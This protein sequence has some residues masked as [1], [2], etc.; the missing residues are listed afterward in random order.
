MK[1]KFRLLIVLFTLLFTSCKYTFCDECGVVTSITDDWFTGSG[2]GK[3]YR[4]EIR[5]CNGQ[6]TGFNPVKCYF[7]SDYVFKVGDTI[8]FIKP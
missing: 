8:N 7:L 4:I 6:Y 3:K 2:V 5:T 1:N